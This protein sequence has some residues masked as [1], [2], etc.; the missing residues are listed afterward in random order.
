MEEEFTKE[1]LEEIQ[2]RIDNGCEEHDWIELEPEVFECSIC[3]SL[4]FEQ[5]TMEQL[6]KYLLD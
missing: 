1:E 4:L 6:M 5:A 2:R 3:E